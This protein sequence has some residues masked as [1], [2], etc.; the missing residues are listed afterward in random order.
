[1]AVAYITGCNSFYVDISRIKEPQ[2]RIALQEEISWHKANGSGFHED[3]HILLIP[4]MDVPNWNLPED[5]TAH[6]ASSPEECAPLSNA[7][8]E[9]F[10]EMISSEHGW[11]SFI[12]NQP[13]GPLSCVVLYKHGTMPPKEPSPIETNIIDVQAVE[14]GG[15]IYI[16]K[17]IWEEVN[18]ALAFNDDPQPL[19]EYCKKGMLV[20]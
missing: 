3:G 7:P 13:G 8:W 16:S 14:Q 20:V 5:I 10:R 11:H 1:M 18:R 6:R 17:Q 2:S 9:P 15:I 12:L 4:E 19:V